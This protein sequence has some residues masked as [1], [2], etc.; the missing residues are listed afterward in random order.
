MWNQELI[1]TVTKSLK[2]LDR[3]LDAGHWVGILKTLIKELGSNPGSE[4]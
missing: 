1:S 3:Q 4:T 2:N